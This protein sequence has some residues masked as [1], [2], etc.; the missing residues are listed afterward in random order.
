MGGFVVLLFGASPRLAALRHEA[1]EA[2]MCFVHSGSAEGGSLIQQTSLGAAAATAFSTLAAGGG[3]RGEGEV[4]GGMDVAASG[5]PDVV[6]GP[7]GAR[8]LDGYGQILHTRWNRDLPPA[9]TVRPGEV[10]QLLC[11]DA[12]D[13]GEAARTLTPEA[14]L[15]LDL[16][17]GH[18]LTGPVGGAGAEPGHILQVEV[19]DGAPPVG[20]RYLVI[21]PALGLF[22]S[23]RHEPLA[24]LTSFTE[25]SALSDP[26]PGR[27]PA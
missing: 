13:I 12:L 23:L 17:R 22:G 19:L 20:F 11:R 10:I 24:A 7:G 25:A 27:V 4:G 5:S 15:T 3:M 2:V 26:S 9:A 16:G 14:S 1:R 8:V 6:A 18:P 21:G